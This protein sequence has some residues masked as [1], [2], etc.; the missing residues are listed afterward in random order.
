MV[1]EVFITFNWTPPWGSRLRPRGQYFLCDRTSDR[2]TV[3]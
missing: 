3:P 1:D 2:R